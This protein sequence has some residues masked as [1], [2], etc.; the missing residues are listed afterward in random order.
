MGFGWTPWDFRPGL[1]DAANLVDLVSI[2]PFYIE[3]L[4]EVIGIDT[5]RKLL[6]VSN[7]Q[8]LKPSLCS[9]PTLSI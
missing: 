1:I 6:L 4:F 9:S 2:M 3:L 5:Y 8:A 7:K